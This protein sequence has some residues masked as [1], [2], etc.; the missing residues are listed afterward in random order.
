VKLS[1]VELLKGLV[2]LR[3]RDRKIGERDERD[4]GDT[5]QNSVIVRDRELRD[6]SNIVEPRDL[7]LPTL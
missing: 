1:Q 6:Q 4:E 5:D 2:V 3:R 7:A